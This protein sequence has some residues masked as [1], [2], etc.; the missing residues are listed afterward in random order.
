MSIWKR[1]LRRIYMFY[2][3]HTI[4]GE[5]MSENLSITIKNPK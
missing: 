5:K 3:E 2:L 1:I 4:W